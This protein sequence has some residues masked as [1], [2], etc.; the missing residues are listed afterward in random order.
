MALIAAVLSPSFL[1]SPVGMPIPPSGADKDLGLGLGKEGLSM[2]ELSVSP[3]R[4]CR[5]LP[6]SVKHDHSQ[7]G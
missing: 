5:T 4:P 7:A 3:Y 2:G 1:K 6:P